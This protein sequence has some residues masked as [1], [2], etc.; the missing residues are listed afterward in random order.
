[1]PELL[2][3]RLFEQRVVLLHGP[4]DDLSA[5]C[6]SAELMTLDA[7]GDEPVTLR[8]DCGDGSLALA[9]P[10]MDVIELLGVP[11]HALCLGQVGAG[12]VGVVA[13]VRVAGGHAKHALR[14]ARAHDGAVA[15]A[16]TRRGAMV[17]AADGRGERFC[18]RVAEAARRPVA[19]VREDLEA[20]RYL[21]TP[22]AVA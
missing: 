11:V 19:Q 16:R 6:T 9:L 7:E 22:A 15:G 14:V 5:A 12:A 17:E 3:R 1:M 20:N 13:G 4:L 8:V 10:L 21:D 18:A 2:A